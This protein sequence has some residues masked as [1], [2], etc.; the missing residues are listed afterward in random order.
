MSE[1]LQ[2]RLSAIHKKRAGDVIPDSE[3]ADIPA[4]IPPN[5]D[6]SLDELKLFSTR[7]QNALLRQGVVTLRLLLMHTPALLQKNVR[8]LGRRGV[9]EIEAVL[10]QWNWTLPLEVDESYVSLIRLIT[11]VLWQ[12]PYPLTL[13]VLA[14]KVDF[15][16]Q[17]RAKTNWSAGAVAMGAERHPYVE[18]LD[19]GKYQLE[20]RPVDVSPP[21]PTSYGDGKLSEISNQP[22][23]EKLE[24]SVIW[25]KEQ[26]ELSGKEPQ[27]DFDLLKEFRLFSKRVTNALVRAGICTPRLLLMHTPDLLMREVKKLGTASVAE[28]E[29]ELASCGWRLAEFAD[30]RYV[31]LIRLLTAVTYNVSYPLHLST[32]VTKT[33]QNHGYFT[34]SDITQ[35]IADHPYLVEVGDDFYQLAIRSVQSVDRDRTAP[36]VMQSDASI[37]AAQQNGE[38]A[39]LQLDVLW[40][41]WLGA[42]NETAREALFL[43]YGVH[44]EKGLTL[45]E[46]GETLRMSRERVRQ[47]EKKGL[48]R[49]GDRQRQPYWRPLRQ[50][51]AQGMQEAGGLLALDRWER[52]LDENAVWKA[53]DPRPQLLPLLCAVLDDY[54]FLN[55][56]NV[57]TANYIKTEHLTQ[58][59]GIL[60]K[61]LRQ[62]K[63]AGLS[64]DE[65][66]QVARRQRPSNAPPDVYEPA[67]IIRA[68]DFFERVGLGKNG[69]YFYLKQK[70]KTRHPAA[71]TGWE[72]KPGT[73]LHEWEMKLRQ[74][75]E[76]IAWIGQLPLSE[77]D[78]QEL[79]R[80]IQVEAQEP[81][82]FSK[83]MEGQPRL[84]PPAVFL[85]TMTLSARYAEQKPDEAVD[86]FWNPYLRAV[87]GVTYS[88]AFMARCRK[89]FVSV[90][91]YLE[92]TFGFEFPQRSGGD[93][94]TPVFRHALL[95]RYM[96]VDFADWL[97]KNWR[98]VLA[99]ADTPE[100]LAA[101]LQ[102]ERSL[103]LYYSHRLKQFITGKATAATAAALVA[104]MAA[105]I[106]LHINDG[107]TIESISD[108]LSDTPIEQE[109]WREL[110]QVFL[111]AQKSQ[112][113]GSLRQT[114]PRLS[115]IWALDAEEIGLRVQN[116]ILPADNGL[117]GEPDRLVWLESS[118]DDP[119]SAE[120]EK[121]VT[122]WRMQTGERIIQNV[123]FEE[124]DGAVNGQ[125]VLLTD[126]DEEAMRLDLPPPLTG[127]VQFFRA[128]Q[129]GAYGVPVQPGQVRDGMWFVCAAQPLT[130]LDAENEPIE[131]DETLPV[132]YPLDGRFNW[133]AQFTLHLPVTVKQGAKKLLA[134]KES[135][136]APAI[137]R[138]VLTGEKPLAPLSRQV[139]PTFANTTVVLS[140]AYGGERLLKQASLWI[141]GQD[142]WRKQRPLS[143]LRQRGLAVL[144]ETGLHIH[145]ADLLPSRP[146]FY[147]V[148]LRISLQPVFPAPLQ[149]AVV[150][151]L[152]VIPPE[153]N[154]IYTPANPPQ[155]ELG[156]VDEA[157]VVRREGMAVE[158]L[159]N[160]RQQITWTDLRHDPRFTLRFD[161]VDIPLAWQLPRFMA[162]LEPKPKRPFLTREE[163][164]QTTLHAVGTRNV[165]EQFTLFIPGQAGRR[166]IS[167]RRG[168]YSAVIGHSQLSDMVRLADR[169]RVIVKAQVGANTWPLFTVRRRPQLRRARVEYDAA[170][171]MVLFSTGLK[172]AWVGNGRFL[173][174]SLTNPFLPP[175]ELG[176]VDALQDVHFLPAALPDGVYRL[177]V[178]LDGAFLPL[179]EMSVRFT[180]GASPDDLAQTQRLIGE[181]RGGQI[182]SP[183]LAEDFVL[184][185][186]EVAE[187]GAADLTPATLFQLA[188]VPADSFTNFGANH[189]QKLWPPLVDL[190][191]VQNQQAWIEEHGALPAWLLFST[192]VFLKLNEHGW[193]LPVY[194][195]RAMQKGR[196]GQGYA[197]W[198]LS[199][200]EGSPKMPVFV[201]WR[202]ASGALV[203]MEAGLP[204]SV[205]DNDWT[206]VDLLD[207]YGLYYCQRC[208]RLTGA[209]SFTLPDEIE[210]QHKHGRP[211]A[212]LR[213]ITVPKK[214]GGFDLMAELLI[215]RRG[216]PLLYAYK[217][218]GI[219]Y[220][221]P[222]T[223]YP[224]PSL[225]AANP[226]EQAD[227][228]I[229]LMALI[230]EIKRRGLDGGRLPLW[231]S[232]ARVLNVWRSKKTVG[233]LGQAALALGVLL[234]TAAYHR[235]QF[236]T[237]L[238]DSHLSQ[239][240]CQ[241]LLSGFYEDAPH[242]TAWGLTWAELL[243]LHSL[244]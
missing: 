169:P 4:A 227:K 157:A 207:S 77:A 63:Q 117:E 206:A 85:T 150:P 65:L 72:G 140:I 39:K 80:I 238:K 102:Q 183:Q 136:S 55:R 224:E 41:H 163:L 19:N 35:A 188:T 175:A 47:I 66:V 64:A 167:L 29:A 26:A 114:K 204:D 11:A 164:R 242:H 178:E 81:N 229:P 74:Q 22:C 134:L 192:P 208:G 24:S 59:D 143:D 220:P 82:Y 46:V 93:V 30:A 60:K 78:F 97:R 88:Q 51:L 158:L 161:K 110:A 179:D 111:E 228:R 76:K 146:N 214:H 237:L 17:D 212:D 125:L 243:H 45:A 43:R 185:W 73:R 50:L 186:A 56:F 230:R 233:P 3:L 21:L 119:L 180:V 173:A 191:A 58:L 128:T 7:V 149:F 160:G 184:W 83:V 170:E 209:K 148:E 112:T 203:H 240:D 131:P 27:L 104:N 217:E 174:E 54:H 2:T 226:I 202:P 34:Q 239:R 33:T 62:H 40:S 133:A 84:V 154:R 99:V 138:P 6:T 31:T 87:W 176:R 141:Q 194:P 18:M 211:Q 221:M 127:P 244:D 89:R 101:H 49:L 130:F 182:I 28:I 70:K 123:F 5:V 16:N 201:Q 137:A 225:P 218:H 95:P 205:P 23:Y 32:I 168:R 232:A 115:W 190:Q 159:G 165:V 189:L 15:F 198:R 113:T 236:Y 108:L 8:H 90:L 222:E 103:G 155:L 153:A 235:R 98:R 48:T 124:P 132:P 162:W 181:I 195:L 213:D 91:P 145:L 53:E 241:T 166:V 1:P 100:L 42:L 38:T 20:I 139:Q 216:Q 129:Q 75:F 144:N 152:C 196:W 193:Q 199:P 96:Q 57:A 121:E 68:T 116:I 177:R 172:E 107:E 135:G 94:V 197:R 223:Y 151:G 10:Q 12:A 13:S 36:A 147:T 215:D 86:E 61:I 109:V 118:S 126:M 231:D 71:D 219:V 25:N 9:A 122:P 142:G 156:G 200:A 106:S 92:K 171:Q 44:G 52:I 187:A 120:I 105:A 37:P 14:E 234:R 79:C 69:R 210:Q 67:F